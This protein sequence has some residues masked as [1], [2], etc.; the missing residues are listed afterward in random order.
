MRCEFWILLLLMQL[1]I[2][3]LLRCDY[4]VVLMGRFMRFLFSEDLYC[5]N[6]N[7]VK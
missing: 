3:V 1:L 6:C 2:F 4:R 7:P 5:S